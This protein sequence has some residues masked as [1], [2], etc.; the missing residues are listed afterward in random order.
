MNLVSEVNLFP[1]YLSL[2]VSILATCLSLIIGIPAAWILARKDFYGKSLLDTLV[3]LP[4][5]LPPT[6]LGYYLLVVIGRNSWFGQAFE[7]ITG[8]S[9]VFTWQ[10]AVLA[11]SL[12]SIPLLIKSCKAAFLAV[13]PDVEDAARTL[14]KGELEIF[15]RVTVP[16]AWPGMLAGIVLSFARALGDFGTTLIVAGN[17]PNRTQ[18][19]PIAI[20]DALLAGD[21]QTV[22]FLVIL[23]TAVAL[24]ILLALNKLERLG[25]GPY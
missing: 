14:G 25:R 22:N 2:K 18:T 24:A 12:V 1:L 23:M 11:A 3:T 21:S 20:Y 8:F 10:A 19:M 16:L 7:R 6:V 4:V 17:I 15:W 5:V 9:L 13:D